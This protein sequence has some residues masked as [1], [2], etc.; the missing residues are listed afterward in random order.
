[1]EV[2]GLL[3]GRYVACPKT[4]LVCDNPA[5]RLRNNNLLFKVGS[6]VKIDRA[7]LDRATRHAAAAG[8]AT[9]EEFIEHAIEKELVRLEADDSEE[10][11]RKRLKGL[12]YIS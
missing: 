2:A 12:G 11:I 8:Y 6:R 4:T 9:V 7:L 5:K 3:E 10:A 1:M